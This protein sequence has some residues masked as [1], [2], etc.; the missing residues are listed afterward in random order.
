MGVDSCTAAKAGEKAELDDDD[1][2]GDNGKGRRAGSFDDAG[3][4]RGNADVDEHAG[5]NAADTV[6]EVA[7]AEGFRGRG[8]V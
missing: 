3:V 5:I 4:H 2:G 8:A 7:A 1:D 6:D